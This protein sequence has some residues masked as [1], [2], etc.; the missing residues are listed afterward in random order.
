M[1]CTKNTQLKQF[2]IWHVELILKVP[3]SANMVLH[4]KNSVRAWM[5]AIVPVIV[6]PYVDLAVECI[7]YYHITEPYVQWILLF[8]PQTTSVPFFGRQKQAFFWPPNKEFNLKE[9]EKILQ[10]RF[11][12]LLIIYIFDILI[13]NAKYYRYMHKAFKL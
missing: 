5:R 1:F 9:I 4:K 6:R 3:V 12:F 2:K 10:V 8:A 11:H 7:I 13:D